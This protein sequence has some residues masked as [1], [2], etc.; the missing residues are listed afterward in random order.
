[1]EARDI[2]LRPV[3]TEQSM[4]DMDDSKYTFEVDT[5]ATKAQVKRAVKELFDV[6]VKKVNILN[7][8]PKPK[9][10]GRYAGYTKKRRK[11]IVTLTE[12]SKDIE[13]FGDEQE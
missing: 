7:T 12:N 9:R 3:I 8:K 11:A 6:E 10:M 2:I 5:R 1:M 13:I 4:Y